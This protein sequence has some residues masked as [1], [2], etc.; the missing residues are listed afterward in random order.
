MTDHPEEQAVIEQIRQLRV[1]MP[2]ISK[3]LDKPNGQGEHRL[4]WLPLAETERAFF[5]ESHAWAA[6]QGLE[7]FEEGPKA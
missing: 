4:Y 2:A 5:H 3:T 6:R 7:I 1:A